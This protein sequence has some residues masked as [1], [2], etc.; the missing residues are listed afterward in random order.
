MHYDQKKKKKTSFDETHNPGKQEI[1]TSSKN[2]E[3]GVIANERYGLTRV[4]TGE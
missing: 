4:P 1:T 3:V 2:E